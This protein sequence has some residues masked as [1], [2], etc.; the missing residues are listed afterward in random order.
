MEHEDHIALIRGG[1]APGGVWAEL[2]CGDG[3]FT[4]ALAELLGPESTILALDLDGRALLR[5]RE[6]LARSFPAVKLLTWQRD[7]T[8]PL[9]PLAPLDGILLANSLHFV[10]DKLPLL[11]RLRALLPPDGRLLIVEYDSDR[12]NPWVP[13]PFAYPTWQDLAREAGFSQTELL[14]THPSR[15]LGRFYAACSRP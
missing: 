15:F 6:R 9:P 5:L 7:F 13:Y 4:L 8:E 2:G 11:R 1:T 12:G 14:A 10:D 3:A